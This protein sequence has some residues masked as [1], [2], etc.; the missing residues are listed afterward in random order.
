MFFLAGIFCGGLLLFIWVFNGRPFYGI[1]KIHIAN[2]NYKFINPL[3][4]VNY[5][6]PVTFS[7]LQNYTLKNQLN[8]QIAAAAKNGNI[9]TAAFYFQ[10]LEGGR[11][12]GINEDFNYSPGIFLKLPLAIAYY[13][14]AETDPNIL[15]NNLIFTT[16]PNDQSIGNQV[17][18]QDGQAYAASDLIRDM[19]IDDSNSSA[20]ILF[21]NIDRSYLNEVYSDLGI[22]YHEDKTT[23][24][25]LTVKL[26]SLFYRILY[27]S[28]YLSPKDSE[29]ILSTVSE[30]SLT[31][32]LA[33]S[34]PNDLTIAHR[35]RSRSL[36]D[37]QI[38]TNYCGI[39]Y[40]PA[41]P[42]ILC[43]MAIGKN[44]NGNDIFLSQAS[45]T[46]YTDMAA[47]Y[48]NNNSN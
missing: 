39:F 26:S 45:L 15:T 22:A 40:Y 21:D 38:E 12:L 37:K 5:N 11:W 25:F 24:D 28:T 30:A 34:L 41:H 13:K 44:A 6:Q 10:E 42:Y 23:L 48:P 4:A 8:S 31:T 9:S 2:T 7:F 33:K 46:V 14:A 17:D 29:Q 18:L 1:Q 16:Q 36:N 43:A 35:S 32:A 47:R 20:I 27:N 3:L 19:L